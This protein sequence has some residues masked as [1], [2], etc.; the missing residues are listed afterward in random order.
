MTFI[1]NVLELFGII[2]LRFRPVPRVWCVWLV[3]V[4]AACLYFITEIEGQVVLA[5]TG[6]AVVIQ[7][8]I[9]QRKGFVRI[10]GSVHVMWI[11]MFAWMAT[12]FDTIAQDPQLS[13]WIM[14]LLATNLV[15]FIVDI[16]DMARYLRGERAPYYSWQRA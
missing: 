2:Y 1:K 13:A 12:R 11:P 8:M 9:Y 4:N 3:A 16:V 6:P 7:S 10:L 14:L 5:V 15:S